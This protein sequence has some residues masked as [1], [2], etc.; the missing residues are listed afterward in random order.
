MQVE[1]Y[2]QDDQGNWTIQI[3][4][5]KDNLILESVGLT[6]T[7]GQIYEDVFNT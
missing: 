4:G 1:I 5:Q 7:M 3:L 6:L 2:R